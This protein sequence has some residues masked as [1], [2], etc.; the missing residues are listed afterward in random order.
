MRH[1]GIPATAKL[2][3]HVNTREDVT[4]GERTAAVAE[5]FA[6]GDLR[7]LYQRS[8]STTQAREISKD[9]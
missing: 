8:Y 9:G 3:C 7:E 6:D 2:V 5:V 1:F 4:L